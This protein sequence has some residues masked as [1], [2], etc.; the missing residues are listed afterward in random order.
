MASVYRATINVLGSR[1]SAMM[2]FLREAEAFMYSPNLLRD[3]RG[4]ARIER[5]RKAPFYS[6]SFLQAG[7]KS[8]LLTGHKTDDFT[9]STSASISSGKAVRKSKPV[10]CSISSTD[11]A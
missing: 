7:M 9:F 5:H 11:T 4:T 10:A 6:L 2:R 8:S 1:C 3:M